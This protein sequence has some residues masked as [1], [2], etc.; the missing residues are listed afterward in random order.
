[1]DHHVDHAVV[2]EIFGALEAVR[3]LLADS[4]LDNPRAGETDQRARLRD[5]HIAQHAVGRG[6]AAGG[7]VREHHDVGLLGLAQVLHRD[8][9]ARQLHE[10]EDALL[11]A[12]AAGSHEHDAGRA[13]FDG[14]FERLDH[15]LAGRHAQR[16]AKEVETLHGGYDRQPLEF[17]EPDLDGVVEPG[18]GARVLE[19]LGVAPLIAELERIYRHLGDFDLL[20]PA[21][22]EQGRE[23]RGRAHTHVIIGA[24]DD[25]LIR[26][27]IFVEDELAGLRA[28]H[29][30]ILRHLAL[31]EAAYLRPD[32]VRD[33]IH[34]D[35]LA[36]ARSILAPRPPAASDAMRSLTAGTVLAVALPSGSRLV[37]TASTRA[38]PTT[39]PSAPCAIV[40]ACSAFLTPKPTAIGKSVWRLMRATAWA[41]RPNSGV[42][43]PV[44]PVID[45]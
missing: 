12:R 3:Q 27:Q 34:R 10:R 22:V 7:R 23:A 41:T 30:Q 9:R 13:L 16:T 19:A 35:A 6:H 26:F 17:A 28:L 8:G 11:H 44:M 2:L 14:V 18:L 40:R 5:L 31:E 32:D 15:S 25:E 33:P 43:A 4:L 38:E 45:T 21:T 37:R 20:V 42:A 29:P 39:T 1:M 24:R 36:R